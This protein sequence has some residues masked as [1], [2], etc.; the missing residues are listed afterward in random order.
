MPEEKADVVGD[1]GDDSMATFA[2]LDETHTLGNAVRFLLNGNTNVD[3]C[4]YSVPHPSDHVV[5]VRVQTTGEIS[6]K[7]ALI[8]AGNQLVDVCDALESS[9]DVALAQAPPPTST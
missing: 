3:F 4:G 8:D 5:H 7:Q 2:L 1:A 6:A 9:F